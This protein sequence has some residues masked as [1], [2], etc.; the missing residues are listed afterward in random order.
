MA[1][2]R[3]SAVMREFQSGYGYRIL[4]LN[5]CSTGFSRGGW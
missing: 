1:L 4:L 2:D 5:R 3:T